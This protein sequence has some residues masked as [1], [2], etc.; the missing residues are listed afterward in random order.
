M[1]ARR[2]GVVLGAVRAGWGL[3]LLAAPGRVLRLAGAPEGRVDGGRGG[4]TA[5]VRVLGCRHVAQGAV[6][7]G[8]WPG[9]RRAAVAADVAHAT[10]MVAL[11]AAGRRWRGPAL[12]DALV[13]TAFA[14]AGAWAGRGATGAASRRS[15]PPAG[16]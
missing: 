15:R 6:A 10:S 8:C 14:A 16:G 13:A 2:R 11:G 7:V 12:A 3:V 1:T 9:W 5:V 4:A